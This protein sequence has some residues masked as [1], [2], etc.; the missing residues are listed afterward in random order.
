M[1]YALLFIAGFGAFALS[2]LTGGGAALMLLPISNALVGVSSTAP[3]VNLGNLIGRPV[4]LVLFWK[5]IDWR[6]AWYYV[7]P[8]LVGTVLGAWLFANMRLIWLEYVLAIFLIS[9]ILQY[10][11]GQ[12]ARSFS[13][14]AWH[15]IPLGFI[16][17]LVSTVVGAT[18]A[19]L[20]PFYMNYGLQKEQLIGTKTANSFFVGI[21]QVGSYAFFSSMHPPL[22]G[23]G[24]ALGLG[25]AIGNFFGKRM[26]A[27][28]SNKSFRI[29]VIWAMVVSGMVM[30][31]RLLMEQL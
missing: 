9:T 6:V 14:R 26:L 16:I 10:R 18:G 25:A 7:P 20:N 24:V 2:T 15:F 22:W 3:V 8:A 4:R 13:V 31:V 30:L 27:K 29:W 5:G 11:F 21:F 23:Y 17:S 12:R 1:I 19:V 28:M